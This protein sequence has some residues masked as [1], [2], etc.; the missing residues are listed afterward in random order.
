MR[1]R[2]GQRSLFFLAACNRQVVH[3]HICIKTLSTTV[4]VMRTDGEGLLASAH[5]RTTDSAILAIA[6]AMNEND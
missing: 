1:A 6:G 5:A 2:G 3:T 4:N